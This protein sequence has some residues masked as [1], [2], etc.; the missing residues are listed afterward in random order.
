VRLVFF[1]VAVVVYTLMLF[2]FSDLF[3]CVWFLV[4][5]FSFSRTG[6]DEW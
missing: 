6:C 2:F 1:V 4:F 3:I 5:D